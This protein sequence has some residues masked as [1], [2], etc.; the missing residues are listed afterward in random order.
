MTI[1]EAKAL[2]TCACK[3]TVVEQQSKRESIILAFSKFWRSNPTMREFAA[4]TSGLVLSPEMLW[5]MVKG[6]H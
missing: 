2:L 5:L 6:A 3:W 1:D 4:Y